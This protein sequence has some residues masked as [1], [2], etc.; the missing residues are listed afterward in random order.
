MSV[1]R[2]R[3]VPE[4]WKYP[5]GP[6]RQAPP[7]HGGEWWLVNPFTSAEPWRSQTAGT[8]ALPVGFA[9]LFGPRPKPV[10]FKDAPNPSWSWRTA[11]DHWEQDLR[12]FKRAGLPEWVTLEELS[13]VEQATRAWGLGSPKFY[14]GK[15]G[16]M[17]RFTESLIPDFE[18]SAWG[19]VNVTHHVIAA[20][21]LRLLERDVVPNERHPFVPPQLWPAAT[22]ASR[23]RN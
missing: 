13:V 1:P 14:E 19:V 17:A 21:Q 12:N 23:G 7:E 9:E 4:S 11:V 3:E 22:D 5:L 10:D 8:A 20:Y 18:A 15:Y 16:W 2:F 6:Y